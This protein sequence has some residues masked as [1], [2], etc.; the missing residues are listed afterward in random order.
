MG[1]KVKWRFSCKFKV[2]KTIWLMKKHCRHMH[3]LCRCCVCVCGGCFIVN[4]C[5]YELFDHYGRMTK[6]EI[7][8][9]TYKITN[10]EKAFIKCFRC[11]DA[12]TK[13]TH[14]PAG[15]SWDAQGIST[16]HHFR[17]TSITVNMKRTHTFKCLLEKK[18]FAAKIQSAIYPSIHEIKP[19]QWKCIF[20][21]HLHQSGH[22]SKA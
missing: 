8:F 18:C 21:N 22:K 13:R 1:S 17:F 10:H 15:G 16:I 19:L 7:V 9:N 2:C 4:R 20:T 5:Y 14:T 11:E 3:I 6:T 12:D